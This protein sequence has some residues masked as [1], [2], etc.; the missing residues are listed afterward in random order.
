MNNEGDSVYIVSSETIAQVMEEHF[1][2]KVFKKNVEVVD[3]KAGEDGYM[4]VL[5]FKERKVKEPN[6]IDEGITPTTFELPVEEVEVKMIGN[7]IQRD[8]KGRFAKSEV[9]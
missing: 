8:N 1:N 5:A 2:R 3:L 7:S 6:V 4:F 9:G